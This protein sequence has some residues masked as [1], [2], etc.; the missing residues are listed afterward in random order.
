MIEYIE[1]NRY[2]IFNPEI[3][4]SKDRFPKCNNPRF[5]F[6]D[7]LFNTVYIAFKI[8]P[9]DIEWELFQ[10]EQVHAKNLSLQP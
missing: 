4:F 8:A 3:Q 10:F 5:V 9:L 7:V 2:W 6:I 1:W